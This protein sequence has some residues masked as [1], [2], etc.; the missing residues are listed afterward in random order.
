MIN[1]ATEYQ[2]IIRRALTDARNY[3]LNHCRKAELGNNTAIAS[4]YEGAAHM[5]DSQQLVVITGNM[6]E[7]SLVA[8]L[9]DD[10]LEQL[11]RQVFRRESDMIKPH[12]TALEKIRNKIAE[13]N[14]TE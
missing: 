6:G 1:W 13:R 2:V 14:T 9:S 7:V 5:I 11:L 12:G 10:E 8:G 4:E 3:R